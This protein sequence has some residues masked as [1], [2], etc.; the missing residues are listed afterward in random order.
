MIG[1]SKDTADS[2]GAEHHQHLTLN[3]PAVT[4]KTDAGFGF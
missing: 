3:P 1:I 4:S 2:L